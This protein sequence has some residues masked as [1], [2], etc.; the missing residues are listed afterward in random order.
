M[1]DCVYFIKVC[2]RIVSNVGAFCSNFV[3]TDFYYK[4]FKINIMKNIKYFIIGFQL[5]FVCSCLPEDIPTVAPNAN[6]TINSP[7]NIADQTSVQFENT[8]SGDIDSYLWNFEDGLKTSSSKSPSYV[9]DYEGARKVKLTA[10]GPNGSDEYFA[11]VAV[12]AMNPTC[13]NYL[14]GTT[15]GTDEINNLRNHGLVKD[16]FIYIKN[17]YSTTLTLTLYSP[18]NW[19]NGKY[20]PK[21]TYTLPSGIESYVPIN[22]EPGQFSND[23]GIRVAGTNGVIS[24]IRTLGAVSKSFN[25][26]RYEVDASDILEGN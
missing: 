11:Y 19:L 4:P 14:S 17:D 16:G 7:I 25:G 1:D 10:N 13:F 15:H 22:N 5:L 8:S 9:F 23:W 18:E 24:C 20:T 2:N 3:S 6:W 21:Y 12:H 26:L